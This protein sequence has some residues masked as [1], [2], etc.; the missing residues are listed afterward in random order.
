[1]GFEVTRMKM[2][3][4]QFTQPGLAGIGSSSID[5][6]V[7]QLA[8]V[9]LTAAQITT[10]HTVPVT[11]IAAP[12]AGKA[13]VVEQAVLE[14]K[15][16]TVAFTGGGVVTLIY[17]GG[18]T[19]LHSGSVPASVITAASGTSATEVGPQTGANGLTL[20]VNA[21]VDISAATA[22]FAAGDGT[23]QLWIWYTVANLS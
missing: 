21:G 13:I 5:P 8:V 18:S 10:L 17:H 7:Q 16:G 22:N 12:G 23:A 15:F 11:V 1:M 2:L 9:P 6:Q 3:A 19:A 4:P 14:F 20:A